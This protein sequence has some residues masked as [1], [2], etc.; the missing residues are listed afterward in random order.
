M[1]PV[2]AISG[3]G[4]ALLERLEEEGYPM[5][6]AILRRALR[7]TEPPLR[8]IVDRTHSLVVKPT[9]DGGLKCVLEV[10]GEPDQRIDLKRVSKTAS[11]EERLPRKRRSI[12]M[13]NALW[14]R[15]GKFGDP[16]TV[17]EQLCEEGVTRLEA[18]TS[19]S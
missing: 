10:A 6:A 2:S 1:T 3:R 5:Y 4:N 17:A 13:S 11:I 18:S 19:S 16:A 14:E 12:R 8:C 7:T 15:L 9:S